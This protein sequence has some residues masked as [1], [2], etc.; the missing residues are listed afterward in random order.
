MASAMGANHLRYFLANAGTVSTEYNPFKANLP[1]EIIEE[2]LY[3][4]VAEFN[5]GVYEIAKEFLPENEVND[6]LCKHC[7]SMEM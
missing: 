3:D 4:N 5:S 2:Q 6:Y 7:K 1:I